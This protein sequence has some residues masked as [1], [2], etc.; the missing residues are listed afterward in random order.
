M[1]SLGFL[2]LRRRNLKVDIAGIDGAIGQI[3]TI[4]EARYKRLASLQSKLVNVTEQVAGLNPRAFRH[5][6]LPVGTISDV[7]PTLDAD[8]L[9]RFS[10][11]SHARQEELARRIG[12]QTAKIFDD[13]GVIAS[14]SQWL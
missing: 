4:P 13:F 2:Q 5:V 10:Y 1:V 8:L 9:W 11:L 7:K 12:T 3:Q 6:S 14:R